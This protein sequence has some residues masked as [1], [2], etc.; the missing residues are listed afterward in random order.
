MK[1]NIYTATTALSLLLSVTVLLGSLHAAQLAADHKSLHDDV[2]VVK[3]SVDL[4]HHN[5]KGQFGDQSMNVDGRSLKLHRSTKQKMRNNQ[6]LHD[7][8]HGLNLG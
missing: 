8:W 4:H 1:T 2:N 3:L 7:W 5:D 6:W